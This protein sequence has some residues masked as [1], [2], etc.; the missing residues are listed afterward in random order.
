MT[1]KGCPGPA[2]TNCAARAEGQRRVSAGPSSVTRC[3]AGELCAEKDAV[4]LFDSAE[5]TYEILSFNLCI[6]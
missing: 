5:R 4:A 1:E 2:L 6:D 3:F